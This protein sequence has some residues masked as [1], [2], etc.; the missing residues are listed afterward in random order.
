MVVEVFKT[1][2]EE[3]KLSELLIQQLLNHFPDSRVNFDMEDCDKILRI[4]AE[5]IVPE[6]II[7]VLNANGY[8]CEVLI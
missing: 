6:K 7:E 2:V 5:A 8:S 3:I 1:N 4:E